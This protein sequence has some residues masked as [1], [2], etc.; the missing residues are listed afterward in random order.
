ME[1]AEKFDEE[2]EQAAEQ[3]MGLDPLTEEEQAQLRLPFRLGGFGLPSQQALADCAWLGSWLQ[4]LAGV[5]QASAVLRGLSSSVTALNTTLRC[6][7][8]ALAA[9]GVTPMVS[10]RPA[11]LRWEVHSKIA[12][13]MSDR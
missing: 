1:E 13:S 4:C 6:S 10:T 12:A 11:G 7:E 3:V 9:T 8:A 2:V 5:V